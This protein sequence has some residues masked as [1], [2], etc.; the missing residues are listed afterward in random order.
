MCDIRRVTG[1]RRFFEV[2]GA[3]CQRIGQRLPGIKTYKLDGNLLV[4]QEIGAFEDDAEGALSNLLADAIMHADHV[5]RGRHGLRRATA[6]SVVLQTGRWTSRV[7]QFDVVEISSNKGIAIE[8]G[9][10]R[11]WNERRDRQEAF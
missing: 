3:E 2:P 7:C 10:G 8:A 4:V 11:V 6:P 9:S 5:G 1:E